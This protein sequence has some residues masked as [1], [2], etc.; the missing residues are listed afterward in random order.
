[1]DAQ[2]M[3]VL[4]TSKNA[5]ALGS[6]G[7]SSAV[8]ST[9]AAAADAVPASTARA[10]RPSRR[11]CG[12]RGTAPPWHGWIVAGRRAYGGRP[13][14]GAGAPGRA[15]P[16]PRP[17]PPGAAAVPGPPTVRKAERPPPQEGPAGGPP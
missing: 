17:P 9:S 4:S 16:T 12:N 6:G 3:I 13:P 10:C 5:A 8:G 1:M 2:T 11:R 15:G 7:T 14:A